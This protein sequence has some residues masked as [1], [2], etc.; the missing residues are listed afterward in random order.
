MTKERG[1]MA[2]AT[3]QEDGF[4]FSSS[5]TGSEIEGVELA[6]EKVGQV[7]WLTC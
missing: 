7:L 4:D 5:L 6:M 2:A 3:R 1:T